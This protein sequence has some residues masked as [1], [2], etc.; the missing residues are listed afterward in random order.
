MRP[1]FWIS[2]EPLLLEHAIDAVSDEGRGG[3]VT[4]TGIVRRQS[5]GKQVVRLEYEAYVAMAERSLREI[6]A[7]A[8]A[9]FPDAKIAIGH[10]IGVL[11]VGD[12]AV[13]IAAA[14]AHRAPAFEACR[15][16]IE[17][18]KRSVPIWKKEI[19]TDGEEWIG[20]GP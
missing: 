9:T 19:T 14:A 8:E 1:T 10:R 17:E 4:F 5:R 7:T 15:F 2:D 13:V 16:A 18:L 3:L 6:G 11:A 20:L 12:I